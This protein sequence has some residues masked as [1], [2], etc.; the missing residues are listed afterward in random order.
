MR[1]RPSR[2]P[3]Q[4]SKTDNMNQTLLV[5]L[6]TEELPPKALAKL[7]DAFA[8]GIVNGLQSRGFSKPT[9]PPPPATPRRLAVSITGVRAASPDKSIREKVPVAVALDA[10]G[11]PPHR[12]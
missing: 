3:E 7:G 1:R 8:A 4:D 9:P 6:V 11:R 2:R 5:E 10:E 12:W